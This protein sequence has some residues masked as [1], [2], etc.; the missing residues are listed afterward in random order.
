MNTLR[1]ILIILCAC[2]E[3]AAILWVLHPVFRRRIAGIRAWLC[4]EP[5][6][7]PQ[8]TDHCE[9]CQRW[10]ECNGV[11]RDNCPLWR[12]NDKKEL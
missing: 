3:C 9:T 10:S 8:A 11:D 5:Q 12:E 4:D 2:L 7:Q 1:I 6:E